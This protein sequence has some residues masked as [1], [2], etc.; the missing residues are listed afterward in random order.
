MK[1]FVECRNI[2][3]RV[4]KNLQEQQAT[5]AHVA[6]QIRSLGRDS[7]KELCTLGAELLFS[8]V[9]PN[10]LTPQ[11]FSLIHYVAPQTDIQQW[12]GK[13]TEFTEIENRHSKQ[14]TDRDAAKRC[15]DEIAPFGVVSKWF[16]DG[17]A[18]Y[19]IARAKSVLDSLEQKLNV[20]SK[21]LQEKQGEL[22]KML[23][24][25]LRQL[26]H[27]ES[28]KRLSDASPVKELD[29][30]SVLSKFSTELDL[31]WNQ[32]VAKQQDSL[33]SMT[34]DCQQLQLSYGGMPELAL[35]AERKRQK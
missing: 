31:V 22:Q 35:L 13:R 5:D 34:L 18:K 29:F 11:E 20:L 3:R 9:R 23:E 15:Y 27:L 26:L 28:L 33:T 8:V 19:K 2:R 16:S 25:F 24:D 7:V 12:C 30:R 10:D 4:L 21:E 1:D 17:D 6:N 14:K 32:H